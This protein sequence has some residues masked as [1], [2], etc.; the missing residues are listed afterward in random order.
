M[1]DLFHVED[2]HDP[3]VCPACGEWVTRRFF[4]LTTHPINP[5]TGKCFM[6]QRW[7]QD[8]TLREDY[9]NRKAKGLHVHYTGY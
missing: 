7:E 2:G 1:S 3:A 8:P 9:L 4:L 6:Q 5:I